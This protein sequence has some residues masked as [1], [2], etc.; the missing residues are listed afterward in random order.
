M[1]TKIEYGLANE[2][3]WIVIRSVNGELVSGRRCVQIKMEVCR[4]SAGQISILH[5]QD[6]HGASL[7]FR[8]LSHHKQNS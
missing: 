2:C 5:Q 4:I 1:D 3:L 6:G 7:S 8:E